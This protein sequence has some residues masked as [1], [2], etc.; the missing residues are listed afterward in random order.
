M[1]NTVVHI[2]FGHLSDGLRYNVIVCT[3][4]VVHQIVKPHGARLTLKLTENEL[5]RI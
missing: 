3:S 4:L 2:L 1:I 5:N